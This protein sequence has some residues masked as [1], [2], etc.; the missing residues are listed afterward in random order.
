MGVAVDKIAAA[1]QPANRNIANLACRQTP[2][3]TF[4]SSLRDSQP[5]SPQQGG[6]H[7]KPGS[8]A[9]KIGFESWD[10]SAVGPLKNSDS[11][12]HEN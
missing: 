2:D 6:F 4:G 8:P 1:D 9:V 5:M 12:P 11:V 7:L 10:M 3:R